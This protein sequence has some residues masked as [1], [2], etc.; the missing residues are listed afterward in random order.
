MVGFPSF[1]TSYT[2]A[3]LK[4]ALAMYS[5]NVEMLDENAA[6]YYL[7]RA[8]DTDSMRAGEGYWIHSSSVV[9]WLVTA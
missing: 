7:R 1:N 2:V 5:L 4:A 6:P 3:D 9:L 8:S